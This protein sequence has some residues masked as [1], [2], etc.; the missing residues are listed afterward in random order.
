[1]RATSS[2]LLPKQSK[3]KEYYIY[4]KKILKL[5]LNVVIPKIEV[6]VSGN[7]FQYVYVKEVRC[8]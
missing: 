2:E 6:T 3:R 5:F 1:M 8:L 7:K 4:I